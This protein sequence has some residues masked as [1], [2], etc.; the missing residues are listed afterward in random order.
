MYNPSSV[1]DKSSL[2]DKQRLFCYLLGKF[3]VW[4]YDAG[5]EV[6]GGQL[7][8]TQLEAD[9][10]AASGAGIVHSLHL[11]SLA[12]DF[13]L[14]V[15]GEFKMDLEAYRTLGDYW[16]SLHPLCCW[17]G[18]FSSPDADHFSITHNGVK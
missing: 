14:F 2:G 4:I 7:K 13:N 8:R 17:G 5:Y 3:L 15:S 9:A 12:I 10:N 11:L 18:D 16:K 1:T 6:T